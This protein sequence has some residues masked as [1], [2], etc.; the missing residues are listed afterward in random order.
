MA[1]PTKVPL[2]SERVEA[3]EQ[4]AEKMTKEIL[5]MKQYTVALSEIVSTITEHKTLDQK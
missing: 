1:N 5:L 3:L 4:L 2:I